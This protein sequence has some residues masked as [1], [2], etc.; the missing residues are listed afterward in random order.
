MHCEVTLSSSLTCLHGCLLPRPGVIPT[1]H[2]LAPDRESS[3]VSQSPIDF[4]ACQSLPCPVESI[5]QCSISL[6]PGSGGQHPPQLLALVL[7]ATGSWIELGSDRH[8]L[9]PL[10]HLFLDFSISILPYNLW[11][12]GRAGLGCKPKVEESRIQPV[13]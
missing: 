10:F 11:P 4:M 13:K 7:T 12:R 9:F 5:A 3:G 8:R 6:P 1:F 2:T